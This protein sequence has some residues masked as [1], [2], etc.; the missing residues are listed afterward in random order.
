MELGDAN[1]AMRD[2]EAALKLEP[3]NP[4]ALLLAGSIAQDLGRVEEGRRYYRRY[5]DAWPSGRK[6]DEI[7]K[8][9]ASM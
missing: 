2:L 8:I 9:L 3:R 6:A 1:G 7:R 5:L 4:Q